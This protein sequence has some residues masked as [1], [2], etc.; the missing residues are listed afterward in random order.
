MG[1]LFFAGI[2]VALVARA[3]A[4]GRMLFTGNLGI[5]IAVVALAIVTNVYV[6]AVVIFFA[7]A[8]NLVANSV[9][10]AMLME[11]APVAQ[12]AKVMNARITLGRPLNTLGA[13][14]AGLL[15]DGGLR[16]ELVIALGGAAIVAYAL[17]ALAV[18]T[19]IAY[20]VTPPG[21]EAPLH[22]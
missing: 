18:P 6:A 4:R 5:G 12:R 9:S 2:Y 10:Q 13:L 16:V 7:G 20:E 15:V 22:A 17:A 3:S 8:A 14:F 19:V 11:T 21:D 1:G